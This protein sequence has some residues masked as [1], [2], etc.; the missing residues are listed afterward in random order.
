MSKQWLP[1][2]ALGIIPSLTTVIA[3]IITAWILRRLRSILFVEYDRS[4]LVRIEIPAELQ[5]GD[6]ASWPII[7]GALP[8]RA[9]GEVTVPDVQTRDVV[10]FIVGKPAEIS[11][12]ETIGAKGW[13]PG[14]FAY[15]VIHWN[16]YQEVKALVDR[17]YYLQQTFLP[18][19]ENKPLKIPQARFL[20]FAIGSH[21]G[22]GHSHYRQGTF[23]FVQIPAIQEVRV[24]FHGHR[25]PEND[26]SSKND[27]K[28]RETLRKM[29][30]S[31][32]E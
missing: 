10:G 12:T 13:S 17:G 3:G 19:A 4:V 29:M 18:D 16:K 9:F 23:S 24:P 25:L 6:F 26:T 30:P 22:T 14:Y 15:A 28:H 11:D 1:D 5:S 21:W 31:H 2:S 32:Q 20:R 7:N 8:F 27:R